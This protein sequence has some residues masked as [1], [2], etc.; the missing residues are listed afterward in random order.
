MPAAEV[1]QSS[2][3]SEDTGLTQAT[4]AAFHRCEFINNTITSPAQ[5]AA[6]VPCAVL[7]CAVSG[8][9]CMLQ[10]HAPHWH[11]LDLPCT[12]CL[13]FLLAA[14]LVPPTQKLCTS[15]MLF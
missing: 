3:I 5:G 12:L 10:S 9:A 4:T 13:L 8:V 7:R 6:A 1:A 14:F 15:R 2:S 11:V